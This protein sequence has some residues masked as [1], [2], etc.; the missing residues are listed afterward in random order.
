MPEQARPRDNGYLT[1]RAL[2]KKRF[3]FASR[4][5]QRPAEWSGPVRT[6]LLRCGRRHRAA[7]IVSHVEKIDVL[8]I[9]YEDRDME[10][11]EE[12]IFTPRLKPVGCFG[13]QSRKPMQPACLMRNMFAGRTTCHHDK[14]IKR[15]I[16]RL[17]RRGGNSSARVRRCWVA[18]RSRRQTRG[19]RLR[20][21][22]RPIRTGRRMF[23]N[24]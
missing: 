12:N 6:K 5:R 1:G 14:K 11:R 23:L 22:P 24:G 21:T 7:K 18:R 19:G 13:T 10:S 8:S 3:L 16:A 17:R 9:L 15:P 2:R 20:S 4:E